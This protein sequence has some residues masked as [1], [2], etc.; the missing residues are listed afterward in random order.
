MEADWKLA[1]EKFI[2]GWK[3]KD[4][5]EAA[6]LTGS[7]ALGL[8]TARSDIDVY[9]VLSDDVDWRERGNVVVDGFLIE[10]F[11]N[12][13]RQIRRY[14]EKEL[15]QNSRSTARIIT[16]GKV[17][18]DKTGIAEALKSEALEYMKRP[19]ERPDETWVEIAKYFLWDMLDS[20]KDAEDRNDPSSGYL[21]NLALNRAL[22]V[23]SKFLGVE[24]PPASKVYRLFRDENFRRAYLYLDFPDEKFVNLFLRGIKEVRTENVEALI[25]YILEQM[26]GFR[27]DGWRLRMRV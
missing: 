12:P 6:L 17:L 10:Y 19:F 1:L 3:T 20:L 14:F 8:Q 26:G 24:I 7:Y 13:A 23:Y 18:F 15:V 2:E 22:E 11:A 25:N 21:Y 27:I 4:F 5:V 9:I 16:I